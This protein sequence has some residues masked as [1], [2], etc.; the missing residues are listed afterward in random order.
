M[1][2]RAGLRNNAPIYLLS[3]VEL[4]VT[5]FNNFSR[6]FDD[7]W[8]IIDRFSSSKIKS[9]NWRLD[10][11]TARWS[12]PRWQELLSDARRFLCSV[13]DRNL[14]A[15]STAGSTLYE[16]GCKLRFLMHWMYDEGYS[17]FSE[18]TPAVF[19]D[20]KDYTLSVLHDGELGG[21]T[22]ETIASY[23]NV[24][25]KIYDQST[26][27]AKFPRLHLKLDPLQGRTGHS[28]CREIKIK[29]HDHILP[30]PDA[31]ANPLLTEA[32]KWIDEYAD[33]IIEAVELQDYFFRKAKGW[34]SKNYIHSIN[35]GLC[36]FKFKKS[37]D[38]TEWRPPILKSLAVRI[39]SED[40][41]RVV[42]QTPL[43]QLSDIFEDLV[44]ACTIAL[45]APVGF[46]SSEGAS[47]LAMPASK[48]GMPNCVDLR[49][50]LLGLNEIF[51]IK[52]RLRKGRKDITDC[53]WVAGVRPVGTGHVP[54]PIR[55]I[56][57][58]T[59]LFH[60]WRKASGRPELL[61]SVKVSSGFARHA[62]NVK[63][64]NYST[65]VNY[66]NAFLKKHVI[67]P[68]GFRSWRITRAQWRKKFA[69][70]I[71]RSDP[72]Q[73]PVVRLHFHQL[74][75]HLI[76]SAY[77]GNDAGLL[78]LI[79]DEAVLQS[80]HFIADLIFGEEK[81]YGKAA[82]ILTEQLMARISGVEDREAAIAI[83]SDELANEGLRTWGGS[84]GDCIF[85][86]ESAVCHV[87]ANDGLVDRKATR[88]NEQERCADICSRC[89]NV[90]IS[91]RHSGFWL[92]RFETKRRDHKAL[93]E[94][95]EYILAE[96]VHQQMM[97]A[98][99]VL[100][101]LGFADRFKKKSIGDA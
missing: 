4:T 42:L 98:K 26:L 74:S 17:A 41:E 77:F 75:Q 88:P 5:S 25:K 66:E 49:P 1:S 92:E 7:I 11:S 96:H 12:A 90:A 80:A 97:S 28:I 68:E 34:K 19:N 20:Y 64:V 89:G 3:D 35:K 58:L 70:D 85:R 52:G 14:G 23:L 43:Q 10:C 22:L 56:L 40:G 62:A 54:L 81:F 91:R 38:G 94:A 33:G 18:L 59:R 82:E 37:T 48:N 24:P 46:R 100:I 29:G 9:L 79:E 21:K 45:H 55:A 86:W 44:G 65:L 67:V 6:W 60:I 36:G 61:L 72:E 84:H 76:E 69:Q 95:G 63:G 30:V 47:L 53:E 71:I 87:L 101:A 2:F 27:F 50:S 13:R 51:Y 99:S 39:D 78:K 73:M 16:L 93:R 32:I 31:V 15:R 8:Y 83:I 57:I